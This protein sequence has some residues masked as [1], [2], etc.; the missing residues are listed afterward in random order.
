V[1]VRRGIAHVLSG[2]E[3]RESRLIANNQ[4]PANPLIIKIE[5]RNGEI[6]KVRNP[7]R[8]FHDKWVDILYKA[9]FRK[10]ECKD[11]EMNKCGE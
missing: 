6:F 1:P 10:C 5:M 4:C 3:P 8:S 11:S 2:Y 9:V 7:I